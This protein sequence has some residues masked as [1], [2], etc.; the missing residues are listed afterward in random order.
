MY[1]RILRKADQIRRFTI[2]EAG[3]AGWEVR[4]EADSRIIRSVQ[5]TDWHRVE[6]AR[7]V[8]AWQAAT[9]EDAGWREA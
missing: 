7:R 9:L 3:A 5:Y 8:F 4:E 6:R 2:R 1:A